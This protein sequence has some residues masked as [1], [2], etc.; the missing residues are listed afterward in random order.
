MAGVGAGSEFAP[1]VP[2]AQVPLY[3]SWGSRVDAVVRLLTT[4]RESAPA[5]DPAAAKTVVFSR[6]EP[7]LRLLTSACAMN[8]VRAT[9]FGS[10]GHEHNELGTFISDPFIQAVLLS[11][12]RDASG[13]TLTAASH[14]IICEP[15]TDVAIEQQM[16]G[17]VHRIGQ[18]RQTHIH[19]VVVGGTF[20]STITVER[21][22]AEVRAADEAAG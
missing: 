4:F 18:T 9:R 13:L 3:G 7:L 20:E 2:T 6:H 16:V 5:A 15:Q 8:G 17:R 1:L 11:A 22:R 21:L 12:Q 19:R 10:G 14:V